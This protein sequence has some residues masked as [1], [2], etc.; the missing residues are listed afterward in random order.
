MGELLAEKDPGALKTSVAALVRQ[1]YSGEEAL[2][3]S[4]M[5]GDSQAFLSGGF[6]EMLQS[7]DVLTDA[8]LRVLGPRVYGGMERVRTQPDT[9]G[10][11]QNS[12]E[13][14]VNS[15]VP[16]PSITDSLTAAVRNILNSYHNSINELA[17]KTEPLRGNRSEPLEKTDYMSYNAFDSERTNGG[18][19]GVQG[20]RRAGD[21]DTERLFEAQENAQSGGVEEGE[22]R[23]TE[24]AWLDDPFWRRLLGRPEIESLPSWVRDNA[25]KPKYG[26]VAAEMIEQ[27]ADYDLPCLV[28]SAEEWAPRETAHELHGPAASRNGVICCREDISEEFRGMVVPHE[29]THVMRQLGYEPY[30]DFVDRTPSYFRLRSI[31]ASEIFEEVLD[32]LDIDSILD[33]D[34][35]NIQ[36]FYDEINATIYGHI[37]ANN[38]TNENLAYLRSAFYDFDAYAEE[39]SEIHRRFQKERKS[40]K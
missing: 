27:A 14:P 23:Q 19:D 20:G 40:N 7:K 13:S 26:S 38:L 4:L 24:E 6:N 1:D 10:I 2:A 8:A 25:V 35:D 16:A 9:F 32:H 31:E 29:A 17:G 36:R 33:I 11:M 28:V 22:G 30:I 21:Q 34:E 37:A 5:P 12:I 15:V 39:L 18:E 3:L